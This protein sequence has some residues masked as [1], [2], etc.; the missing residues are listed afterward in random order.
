MSKWEHKL[1][2]EIQLDRA[3]LLKLQGI[4]NIRNPQGRKKK[5]PERHGEEVYETGK[6]LA[7]NKVAGNPDLIYLFRC[8]SSA[9]I[10]TVKNYMSK[11]FLIIIML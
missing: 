6:R 9:Y 7:K 5:E 11:D 8:V 1:G 3:H 2:N 4:T 10:N